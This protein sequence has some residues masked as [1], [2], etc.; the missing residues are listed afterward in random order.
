MI[1]VFALM[2]T[3]FGIIN[4]FYP[5][6]GW[7]LSIGWR[8]KD[9]EPSNAALA[10]QRFSGVAGAAIGVVILF[11]TVSGAMQANQWPSKF[12]A[13]VTVDQIEEMRMRN[14]P[15]SR[16]EIERVVNLIQEAPIYKSGE[17][18]NAFGS[19]GSLDIKFKNGVTET[20][21]M[22]IGGLEIHPRGMKH[23]YRV[24]SEELDKMLSAK[25]NE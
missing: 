15:F 2:I 6:A 5:Y 19:S 14:T 25:S 3:A 7:Y 22:R 4:V 9:A 13:Q 8:L 20:I 10:V 21:Y 17:R 12:K 24:E 16:E 1:I 11:T 18:E 23:A